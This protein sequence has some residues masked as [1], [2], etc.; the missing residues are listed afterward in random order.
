[1]NNTKR[2]YQKRLNEVELYFGVIELLD[3]GEC[4]I[5]CTDILGN[6]LSQKIDNELSKI[7]KANGFLLL[8]NLVEATIRNSIDAIFV[9]MHNSH[10]TF[11][12][13]TDN[14]RRLWIRQEFKHIDSNEILLLANKILNNELLTFKAECINISGNIDAQ[15]IRDISKQLGCAELK[16]GRDLATIKEKRNKLAHGESTFS[17]IGKDYTMAELIA[18]KDKTKEYLSNVLNEIESYINNKT[19]NL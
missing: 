5:N 10:V 1:M 18:F 16:D 11:G 4:F 17:E 8:Y 6:N 19:Y 2:E 13:L 12:S 14:L 3:K 15:K 7:L 9:S